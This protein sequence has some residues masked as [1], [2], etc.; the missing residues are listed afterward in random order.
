MRKAAR[1]AAQAQAGAAVHRGI[2]RVNVDRP[3]TSKAHNLHTSE[4]YLLHFEIAIGKSY[5]YML[6]SIQY[7]INIQGNLAL[8]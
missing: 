2:P 3:L 1:R 6:V 5:E 7:E 8:V 4:H